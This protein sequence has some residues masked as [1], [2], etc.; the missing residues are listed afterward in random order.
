MVSITALEFAYT[1][2][3]KTMKSIIMALFLLSVSAGNAFAAIVH[4]FIANP[5]GTTKLHGAAYYN[6][7]AL[8]SIGCVGI[9]I[10][11]AKVYKEKTH[12]QGD[13]PANEAAAE[14]VAST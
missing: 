11:V 5:D 4:W 13:A 2:A 9:F 8:L 6:F 10:F 3:P 1:Q 12:L 7:Y 14:T